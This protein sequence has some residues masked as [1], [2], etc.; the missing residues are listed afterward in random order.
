VLLESFPFTNTAGHSPFAFSEA[1]L[2]FSTSMDMVLVKAKGF[3]KKE[4]LITFETLLVQN[5]VNIEVLFNL[6]SPRMMVINT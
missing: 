2:T 3:A 1:N 6:L 4:L 5:M